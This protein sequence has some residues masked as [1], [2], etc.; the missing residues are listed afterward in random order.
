MVKITAYLNGSPTSSFIR[1]QKNWQL[2]RTSLLKWL[3][4]RIV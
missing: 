4:W 2:W 3:F 1:Q